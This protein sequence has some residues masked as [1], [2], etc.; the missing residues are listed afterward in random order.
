MRPIKWV[1]LHNL[2]SKEVI[3]LNYFLLKLKEKLKFPHSHKE[4]DISI[5]CNQVDYYKLKKLSIS[6]I[7]QKLA[8]CIC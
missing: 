8:N 4:K 1:N 5:F 2:K 6:M 3:K 7:F